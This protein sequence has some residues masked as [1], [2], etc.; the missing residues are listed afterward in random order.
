MSETRTV[1][2]VPT[3]CVPVSSPR[4]GGVSRVRSFLLFGLRLFTLTDLTSNDVLS[5]IVPC[6][7][8]V[9]ISPEKFVARLH[10]VP[11]PA[12]PPSR[13]DVSCAVHTHP[14]RTPSPPQVTSSVPL[15][16]RVTGTQPYPRILVSWI[17]ELPV[18][19]LNLFDLF[20]HESNT[21]PLIETPSNPWRA[22]VWDLHMDS[23]S[24]Y[25]VRFPGMENRLRV[26]VNRFSTF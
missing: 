1:T 24:Y 18:P 13:K 9:L 3:L 16:H 4:D 19:V 5:Y 23:L 17:P 26:T 22:S 2:R 10:I 8:K 21:I 11:L 15:R 14:R 25:R 6:L 12:T 20:K 7:G